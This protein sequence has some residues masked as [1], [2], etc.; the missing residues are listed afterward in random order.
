MANLYSNISELDFGLNDLPARDLPC[1]VLMVTPDHFQ[2]EYVINPHMERHIGEIDRGAA[3]RQ[4][5]AVLEAYRAFGLDVSTMDGAAGYPDMVFC[6]NQSLPGLGPDGKKTVVLSN[7]A[8]SQRAEEVRYFEAY[9]L[10][11]GYSVAHAPSTT[12][13]EG[14]GDALWHHDRRLLWCGHGFRSEPDAFE[15]ACSI[16]AV[17]GILLELVDPA[18]YHLDTC[19]CI[20]DS[21]TAM[22]VPGAFTDEGRKLIQTLIPNLLEVPMSEASDLL[23]CNAHSPDGRSVLIQAGCRE[24]AQALRDRGF[25]VVE[26]ETGE[27]LKSGGSVFCMKQMIY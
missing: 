26:V 24:T 1:R 18:F 20:L 15:H 9:F 23:A 12:R 16:F 19:L 11:E 14:C 13:L 4:W 7:M 6:A 22:W 10:A 8:S 5:H 21:D 3:D 27:F 25:N 17:P 2:V